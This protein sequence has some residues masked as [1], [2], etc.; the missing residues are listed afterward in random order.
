MNR[1]GEMAGFAALERFALEWGLPM[2]DI[3]ELVEKL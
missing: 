1:D 3:G 2:I